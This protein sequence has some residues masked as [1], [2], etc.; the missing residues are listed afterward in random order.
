MP[1]IRCRWSSPRRSIAPCWT[2][3]GG[4]NMSVRPRGSGDPALAKIKK[5]ASV[6]P[7]I[8]AF[9]GTS[10]FKSFGGTSPGFPTLHRRRGFGHHQPV[11]EVVA[12]RPTQDLGLADRAREHASLWLR[13]LFP[14]RTINHGA[15][16]VRTVK[17]H[18]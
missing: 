7:W 16:R 8:P 3:F 15:G 6:Q 17:V 11:A 5:A 18:R 13:P 14:G 9:A 12:V 1:V 2:S 4:T 10:G